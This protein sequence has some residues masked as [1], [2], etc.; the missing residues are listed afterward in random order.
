M[1]DHPHKMKY[2]DIMALTTILTMFAL[3]VVVPKYEEIYAYL[4]A[5]VFGWI[6]GFIWVRRH[7]KKLTESK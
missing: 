1:N 4:G 5:F 2:T 6:P 7:N 3:L